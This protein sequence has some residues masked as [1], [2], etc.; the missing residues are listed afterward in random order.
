MHCRRD[1]GF[2]EI[3]KDNP[4][5]TIKYYVTFE[6]CFDALLSGQAD[7]TF[8]D[9]YVADYLL[10]DIRYEQFSVVT[11]SGYVEEISI[12]VSKS[13]DPRLLQFLTG[14]YNIRLRK[15]STK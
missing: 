8:T 9:T 4:G 2:P 11:L 12:G 3:A 7:V 14:V 10:S 13:A 5:R 1:I 6:N 15:P